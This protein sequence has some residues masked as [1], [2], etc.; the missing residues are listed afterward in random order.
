MSLFFCF[1]CSFHHFLI[2]ALLSTLPFSIHPHPFSIIHFITRIHTSIYAINWSFIHFHILL[3]FYS[4]PILLYVYILSHSFIN[5]FTR[6]LFHIHT[7]IRSFVH[8]IDQS[9]NYSVTYSIKQSNNHSHIRFS[10]VQCVW[11]RDSSTH[12]LRQRGHQR[13]KSISSSFWLLWVLSAKGE[14]MAVRNSDHCSLLSLLD[15]SFHYLLSS[16]H[17]HGK[18]TILLSAHTLSFLTSIHSLCTPTHSHKHSS[19]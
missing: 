8:A 10:V 16:F 19:I 18:E 1:T 11:W 14:L 2:S 6:S 3:P 7:Y 13:G 17:A 15:L 12:Q 9:V 5:T 4:H